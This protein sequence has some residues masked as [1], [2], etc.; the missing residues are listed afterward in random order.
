MA[1]K[2]KVS[3]NNRLVELRGSG[4]EIAKDEPDIR[5]WEVKD[6]RGRMFGTVQELLF[7]KESLK[8][9]YLILDLKSNI[10]N[11]K[12]RKVPIPIGLAI[13]DADQD[14]VILP[15]VTAVHLTELPDYKKTPFN[16]DDEVAIRNVFST[17]PAGSLGTAPDNGFYEHTHFNE[18]N[19]YQRRKGEAS[20]TK[21]PIIEEN[22]EVGKRDVESKTHIHKSVSEQPVEEDVKLRSEKVDIQRKEVD[23]P[24]T[25]SE[26]KTFEEGTIE[27]TEKKE[28]PIITKEAK[29]VEEV[30]VRKEV[31][32]KDETVRD[33]VKKTDVKIERLP[34]EESDRNG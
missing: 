34:G 25:D 6:N 5:G 30:S 27:L 11:L 23:R 14:D 18:K 26:L 15:D 13:L 17:S 12:S 3:A 2:G 29:V 9:R 28:V 32:E 33:T 1:N 19:L 4:F 8:V 7:D 16:Y 31:E 22:L 21:I 24:A 10:L 20:E